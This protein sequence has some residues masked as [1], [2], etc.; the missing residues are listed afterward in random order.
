MDM[1]ELLL[2]LHDHLTVIIGQCD[3]LEDTFS[4]RTDVMTRINIIRNAAQRIANT[5]THQPC[6]PTEMVG[7]DR[8]GKV[9]GT[10]RHVTD[11][12]ADR[13]ETNCG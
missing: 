1:S 9:N 6:P 7:E 4:A 5:I 2:E 3:I 10:C 11:V 8:L 13:A 12:I